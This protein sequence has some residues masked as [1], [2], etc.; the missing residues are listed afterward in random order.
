MPGTLFIVATPIGNVADFSERAL[1]VLRDVAVIAVEDTRHSGRLLQTC[2]IN[3]P[4]LSCH[5]YNE[6]ERAEALLT[7]VTAGE[8]IALISDAGTP[9]KSLLG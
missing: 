9:L 4:M 3:T 1:S 5:E 6:M 7:R 8:D 2:G